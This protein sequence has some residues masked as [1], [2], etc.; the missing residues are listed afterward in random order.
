MKLLSSIAAVGLAQQCPDI[1]TTSQFQAI[2]NGVLKEACTTDAGAICKVKCSA[3]FA[4]NNDLWANQATCKCDENQ[5]CGWSYGLTYGTGDNNGD[6]QFGCCIKRTQTLGKNTS[7]AHL[8]RNVG[9]H[10]AEANEKMAL[11]NYKIKIKT[12]A[13]QGYSLLLTFDSILPD[14]VDVVTFAQFEV[15][16]IFR[17]SRSN[18]TFI[19]LNSQSGF[20][21][22]AA[23]DR[24]VY[25]FALQR[26]NAD[27]GTDVKALVL[28]NSFRMKYFN[29]RNDCFCA[30]NSALCDQL[31][32]KPTKFASFNIQVFGQTKYG[33]TTVKDQIV[34]ILN[35]YDVST[36]QEIRDSAETAFPNLVADMNAIE[37]K[38]D[39]H[40]GIR[41]GTTSSKEQVGFIWDRTKFSLVD[42]WDFD[43][44]AT[45]WFERPPGVIV[46]QR[47]GASAPN[48]ATQKFMIISTH[49]KPVSGTSDMVTENE[50]NH[51]KDVYNDGLTR[52][53]DVT[54][55]IIAGD[56]NADCTYVADP[57]A[58]TLFTDPDST[59]VL[60][61]TADTTVKDT[62]CAYDHL[63]LY[64]DIKNNF[65]DGQV[66]NYETFYDTENIFY[67]GEPITDL[68]SDHYP[69]EF[70]FY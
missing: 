36:I 30:G 6:A 17:D 29:R 47:I 61:F 69:V 34:T 63:V 15:S 48:L 51:L 19:M 22:I 2:Q 35:R 28:A 55:A 43:D 16:D 65:Q 26:K 52:H 3:N 64:G 46:L 27:S 20:D 13:T 31:N 4:L 8:S 39:W 60:D 67:E 58:M 14:D 38:Y 33:K 1:T 12:G 53:P 7:K 54:S 57:T 18:K 5:S 37:D 23:N 62:D 40:T 50:I 66:F 24:L 49:I 25:S 56:F 44:S 68:I 32:P 9:N 21:T 45:S 11:F 41:Q 10:F 59:W 42:A 70:T